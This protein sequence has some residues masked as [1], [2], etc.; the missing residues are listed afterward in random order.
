MTAEINVQEL[1]VFHREV[2]K[3]R[4]YTSEKIGDKGKLFGNDQREV[5]YEGFY[6][7]GMLMNKWEDIF[8][9][10]REGKNGLEKISVSP[11]MQNLLL[12][13]DYNPGKTSGPEALA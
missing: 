6:G 12:A 2:A 7:M 5:T 3:R 4:L 8:Y 11:G 13:G 9:T 10:S 1:L